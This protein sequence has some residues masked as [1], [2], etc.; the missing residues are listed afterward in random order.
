MNEATETPKQDRWRL[1]MLDL[2]EWCIRENRL[3]NRWCRDAPPAEEW[4]EDDGGVW[5]QLKFDGRPATLSLRTEVNG[6]PRSPILAKLAL[7]EPSGSATLELRIP[8]DVVDPSMRAHGF[9]V[10]GDDD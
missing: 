4:L 7:R 10:Y 1:H 6:G 5:C 8:R 3:A 2:L 9:K